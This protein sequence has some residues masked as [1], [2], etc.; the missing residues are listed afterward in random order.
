M[1]VS[2][3]DAEKVGCEVSN[4]EDLLA[5]AL[6]GASRKTLLKGTTE[7]LMSQML[8]RAEALAKEHSELLKDMR[9]LLLDLSTGH[10]EGFEKNCPKPV[11][12]LCE[13]DE[14]RKKWGVK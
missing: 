2:A 12:Y 13:I 10:R 14:L 6:I 11:C 7:Q 4:K 1:L 8:E 3:S 9:Y 5:D